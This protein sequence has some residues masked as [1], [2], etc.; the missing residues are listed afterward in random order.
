MFWVCLQNFICDFVQLFGVYG[1][2]IFFREGQRRAG[3]ESQLAKAERARAGNWHG[4]VGTAWL[5]G[6]VSARHGD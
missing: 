2:V 6:R 3:V 5:A 4:P 1:G